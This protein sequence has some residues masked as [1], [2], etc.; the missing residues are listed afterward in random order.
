MFISP[1]RAFTTFYM[2]L[3]ECHFW[4]STANGAVGCQSN[5]AVKVQLVPQ[6]L[7]SCCTDILG[8]SQV[9]VLSVIAGNGVTSLVTDQNEIYSWG[10]SLLKNCAV[11]TKRGKS[12]QCDRVPLDNVVLIAHGSNHHIAITEN[13]QVYGWGDISHCYHKSKSTAKTNTTKPRKISVVEQPLVKQIACGESLTCLLKQ[14][15]MLLTLG[16]LGLGCNTTLNNL[17]FDKIACG[18]NHCAA[19][20]L[21]GGVYT[22]VRYDSLHTM[23]QHYQ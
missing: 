13:N 20:C 16:R 21:N 6:L 8:N 11:K 1:P 22:W 9:K 19:T 10:K 18:N 4:G 12:C 2:S 3:V 7:S 15:G 17:R 5:G 14:N 23:A